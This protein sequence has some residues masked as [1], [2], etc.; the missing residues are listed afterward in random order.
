MTIFCIVDHTAPA[1]RLYVRCVT[2]EGLRQGASQLSD[3]TRSKFRARFSLLIISLSPSHFYRLQR[4]CYKM[5]LSSMMVCC[6]LMINNRRQER[7]T[8]SPKLFLGR[9]I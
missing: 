4:L 8:L 7:Q 1:Y 2:L 5:P 6:S 3:L 9:R